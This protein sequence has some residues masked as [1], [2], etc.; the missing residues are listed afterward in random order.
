MF[1]I[2]EDADLIK[3]N[4]LPSTDCQS[5]PFCNQQESI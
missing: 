1:Q 5:P 2:E 3:I 4:N